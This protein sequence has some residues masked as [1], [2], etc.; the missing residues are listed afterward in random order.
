MGGIDTN[1]IGVGG[2]VIQGNLIGTQRD[3]VSPLPNSGFGGIHLRANGFAVGGTSAGQ[4]N[5]IALNTGWG[6][7]VASNFSG[8][9]LLGN[10][11][12]SNTQLGISLL[13]LSGTPL[14]N[15]ACDVDTVPGIWGRT[16]LSSHRHPLRAAT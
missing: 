7:T 3:G 16:T 10:S 1:Q 11:I 13:N 9:S 14:A 12:Y 15:D 4:G 8:N 2:G 5:T 6:V